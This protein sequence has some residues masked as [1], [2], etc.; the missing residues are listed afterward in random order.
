MIDHDDNPFA[1]LGID[2]ADAAAAQA[3]NAAAERAEAEAAAA[4]RAAAA[5]ARAAAPRA[6]SR[7]VGDRA[8]VGVVRRGRAIVAECGHEHTNRDW[9]TG[10]NGTSA[11]DCARAILAGAANPTTAEHHAT[12]LR[13]AWTALASAAGHAYPASVIAAAQVTAAA[14]ADSYL[15][16]VS[17]VRT[18]TH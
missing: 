16:A 2:P 18:L 6:G 8:Y 7:R 4:Q 12:R 15:S 17:T 1:W 11:T 13:N 5:A 3:A 14:G 9:T 10:A